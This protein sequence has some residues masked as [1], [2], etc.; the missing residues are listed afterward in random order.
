MIEQHKGIFLTNTRVAWLLT[1]RLGR[2][3]REGIYVPPPGWSIKKNIRG[4]R[5]ECGCITVIQ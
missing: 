5:K 1:K 2:L 3:Y 4:E